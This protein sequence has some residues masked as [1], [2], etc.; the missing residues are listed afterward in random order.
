LP[1]PAA[2]LVDGHQAG[3]GQVGAG[4]EP[5][6]LLPV[7]EGELLLDRPL[8][9]SLQPRQRPGV[10]EV[11]SRAGDRQVAAGRDVLR[12]Q[13][14]EQRDRHGP[15]EVEEPPGLGEDLGGDTQAGG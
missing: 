1:R 15:R 14:R 11:A 3:L 8:P 9:G 2:P 5:R 12:Q 7:A 10:H 13:D 4:E 6:R